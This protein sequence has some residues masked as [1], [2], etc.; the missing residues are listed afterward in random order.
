MPWFR[1]EQAAQSPAR[2]ETSQPAVRRWAWPAHRQET[3]QTAQS[4]RRWTPWF[5]AEQMTQSAARDEASQP[6]VRR[7]PSPAHRQENQQTAQLGSRRESRQAN[8]PT[9]RL[10][11]WRVNQLAD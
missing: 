7:W 8:Q 4:A 10:Q 3:Q 6:A 1:A 9:L 5:H 2:D 11:A